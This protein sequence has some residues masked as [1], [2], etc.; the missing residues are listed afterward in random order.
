MFSLSS[1][2]LSLCHNRLYNGHTPI[3]YQVLKEKK[4][5]ADWSNIPSSVPCMMSLS[6]LT[7]HKSPQVCCWAVT[8][9]TDHVFQLY[10]THT[11]HKH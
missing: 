7:I 2:R 6:P 10:V 4:P 3:S 11:V 8:I 9:D 5:L 1:S